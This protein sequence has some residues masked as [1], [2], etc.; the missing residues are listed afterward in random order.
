MKKK[1]CRSCIIEVAIY[2]AGSSPKV[3]DCTLDCMIDGTQIAAIL[4]DMSKH[5]RNRA[6]QE[7]VGQ[8]FQFQNIKSLFAVIVQN[9]LRTLTKM[10]PIEKRRI[11]QLSS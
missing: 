10:A 11:E 8:S 1:I 6:S 3:W 7:H 4:V 5:V 9:K 2:G